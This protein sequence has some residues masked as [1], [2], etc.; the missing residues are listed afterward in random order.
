MTFIF[1]VVRKKTL[2]I[3]FQRPML[4]NKFYEAKS[5]LV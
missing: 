5:E 3:P 2:L 4:E 1:L